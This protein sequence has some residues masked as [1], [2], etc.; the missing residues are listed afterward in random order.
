MG[1]DRKFALSVS[2]LAGTIVGAGVFSL[3]YVFKT[4]GLSSGFFYLALAT[5]VYIYVYRM[6]A[7]IIEKTPGDHRFVG[8]VRIYFGKIFSWLAVL[9]AV[10][11]MLLVL[12]IYLILSQSFGDLTGIFG[13]GARTLIIFWLIGSIWI[14]LGGRRIAISEFFI[15]G[16]F[17][18]II[19]L[20]LILGFPHF[21][22]NFSNVKF[23]PDWKNFL[24]PFA[25]ILF[26]LAGRQAIPEMFRIS[27][28]A[29]AKK[30]IIWGTIIPTIIFGLFVISVL[31]ISPVVSEDSVMGLAGYVQ[32]WVLIAVGI[33]G[34]LA[35]L[36][37][38][39][40]IGLDVYSTLEIDLKFSWWSRFAVIVF[41]PLIL[42]FAGLNN[43][44]GLVSVVGGVFLALEGILIIWM[45]LRVTGKK[46]SLPIISLLL[47]FITALI[48]EIIK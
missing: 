39:A 24:L 33:I 11:E 45:W 4:A 27:G 8:Y 40:T 2:L 42:Y 13:F 7:D 35:I 17:A 34:I 46:L 1:I 21:F 23:L 36:S 44:L 47:V 14:F 30:A 19:L 16:G 25:P 26:S 15:T 5:V 6:Y 20:M 3:P 28:A 43:F 22:T 41:A 38:Y 31:A 29:S 48:Y 9:M 18:V 37:S 32:S 12:T 10:V